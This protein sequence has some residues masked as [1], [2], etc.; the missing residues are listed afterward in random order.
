[1]VACIAV[2]LFAAAMLTRVP[3]ATDGGARPDVWVPESADTV[4]LHLNDA[5]GALRRLAALRRMLQTDPRDVGMAGRYSRLALEHYAV[6]G[7]ARFLGFA[8]GALAP[9][10]NDPA[11]PEAI[12]ILRARVLQTEHRFV[13]A[14]MELDR[15]LRKH[16]DSVESMLLAADAWRRA[17]A[18]DKAKARC[19]GLALAGRQDLA[20]YCA[21]DVLLSLGEAERAWELAAMLS[22]FPE[23]ADDG[24]RQWTL[25]VKADAAAAAGR[26]R[27]AE[28]FYRHALALPR[29]PIAL[30]VAYADLLLSNDR[31]REA[32]DNLA[33]LPEADAVLLR[34]AM[35]ARRLGLPELED[36]RD[37]LLR[38]FA[39]AEA[40]GTAARHLREKA[41]FA[42]HVEQDPHA[43]LGYARENWRI[44][45]GPEDAAILV[46]SA[47]AA[48]DLAASQMVYEW[49]QRFG[50]ASE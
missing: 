4:V 45:K 7:D 41:M 19:A 49:R 17:G 30:H 36:Y 43:A 44:Q 23:D 46:H 34:R 20:R 42:L 8:E 24:A 38:R 33:R 37:R 39:D 11:P 10:R 22:N 15:L 31:P 40:L 5:D 27:A 3:R 21:A 28:S 13:D 1:M 26:H 18:I 12:W 47:V 32:L 14:A 6:T 35:A 25:G 2:A 48:D 16:A 50:A 29:P 9:W